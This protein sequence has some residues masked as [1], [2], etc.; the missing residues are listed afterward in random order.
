M[1]EQ[2]HD[3]A[4]LEAQAAGNTAEGA[5]EARRPTRADGRATRAKLL[6]AARTNIM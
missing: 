1:T 2:L 5:K 6:D 4:A 3:A